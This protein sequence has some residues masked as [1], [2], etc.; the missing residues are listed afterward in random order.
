MLFDSK[1]YTTLLQ[2]NNNMQQLYRGPFGWLKKKVS[3][4]DDETRL[5]HNYHD[6]QH[7]LN[8]ALNKATETTEVTGKSPGIFQ[9]SIKKLQD[10]ANKSKR[11]YVI[12]KLPDIVEALEIMEKKVDENTADINKIKG[13]LKLGL[14]ALAAGASSSWA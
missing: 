2:A 4:N 14:G 7:E 1:Q 10:R 13:Q 3:F 6:A 8:K 9:P 12:H 11:Q 5:Y